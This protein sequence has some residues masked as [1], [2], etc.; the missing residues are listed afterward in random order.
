M[1][2]PKKFRVES[3]PYNELAV[4]NAKSVRNCTEM[5]LAGRNIEK[6]R[7]FEQFSN[8]EILWLQNNKLTKINCLNDN[9]RIK[10]LYV[11][12]NRIRTLNGS[13]ENFKFLTELTLF[14]NELADLNKQLL[15][16]GKFQY[17]EKLDL[18]GNPVA[19]EKYYRLRVI[20]AGIIF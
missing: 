10:Y 4:K 14:N 16:L 17:L 3:D 6:I 15:I 5:F 8:I 12:D 11:H 20:D 9:I 7:G 18:Y 19:E 1:E 2:S 13:L